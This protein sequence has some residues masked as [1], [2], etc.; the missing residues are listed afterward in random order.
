MPLQAEWEDV[1]ML[2]VE[3]WNWQL[4]P[5]ELFLDDLEYL[6]LIELL[7][8]TL[9]SS[10]GFTTIALCRNLSASSHQSPT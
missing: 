1:N 7:G 5:T 2:A 9:N 10:Q 6:L 8:K 3:D 4:R